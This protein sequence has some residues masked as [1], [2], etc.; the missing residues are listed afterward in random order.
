[1]RPWHR[2]SWLILPIALL[3]VWLFA[4]T[5]LSFRTSAAMNLNS[6][7]V[8]YLRC[9]VWQYWAWLSICCN[10][11]SHSRQQTEAKQI[12]LLPLLLVVVV[13]VMLHTHIRQTLKKLML[14]LILMQMKCRKSCPNFCLLERVCNKLFNHS[15]LHRMSWHET[16]ATRQVIIHPWT[17]HLLNLCIIRS[18]LTLTWLSTTNTMMSIR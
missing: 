10:H 15:L 6:M 12:I 16:Y 8:C 9:K 3:P 4:S 11:T 1:M 17:C 2:S 13:V 7:A 5:G 18:Y 14:V